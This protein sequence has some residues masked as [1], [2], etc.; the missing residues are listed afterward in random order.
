MRVCAF[1]HLSVYVWIDKCVCVLMYLC[2]GVFMYLWKSTNVDLWVYGFVFLC[3]CVKQLSLSSIQFSIDG[4][5]LPVNILL[6]QQI[7]RITL[8]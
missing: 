7:T 4:Y 5:R 2:L 1:V 3:D 8:T 6:K